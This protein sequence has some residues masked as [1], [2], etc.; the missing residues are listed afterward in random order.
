MQP[1]AAPPEL[2]VDPFSV[3]VLADPTQFQHDLREAGPVA[4]LPDYGIYATGRFD[5]V[6]AVLP[7]HSRFTTTGGVGLS[8]IPKPDAWR[9]KNPLLEI[10]PPDHGD[11][12]SGLKRIMSPAA[13]RQWQETFETEAESLVDSLIDKREFDGAKDL[14][15][16]FVTSVFPNTVGITVE[17]EMVIKFGDLNFNANGPQNELYWRAHEAVAPYLPVFE[18]AFQR[19]SMT[20]GGIGEQI[21]NAE[22]D[23]IFPEGTALGLVRVMFQIGR[24]HV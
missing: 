24:E 19:E 6:K 15:E 18:R 11:I 8:D 22:R 13:I 4:R 3:D 16:A 2:S 23:G 20:P 9:V 5:E 12:R 10:D 7:D 1:S 21:Y 17:R 14:A